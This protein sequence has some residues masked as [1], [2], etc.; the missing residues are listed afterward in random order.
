MTAI[1]NLG[2]PEII[3]A[4]LLLLYLVL[5]LDIYRSNSKDTL[6]KFVWTCIV[7][8]FPCVGAIVYLSVGRRDKF[9]Y[10]VMKKFYGGSR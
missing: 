10:H 8:L 9:L 2:A 5:F 6:E 1:M 3:L 7:L 4:L